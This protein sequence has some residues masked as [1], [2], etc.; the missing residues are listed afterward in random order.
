MTKLRFEVLALNAEFFLSSL[1]CL[2][3]SGGRGAA[4]N[5]CNYTGLM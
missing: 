3:L 1:N 2:F 5:V 4:G